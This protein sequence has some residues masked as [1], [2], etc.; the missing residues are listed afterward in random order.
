[1]IGDAKRFKQALKRI[2]RA[3]RGTSE[4]KLRAMARAA[5]GWRD[6]AHQPEPL[7]PAPPP[8]PVVERRRAKMI[9]MVRSGRATVADARRT[10]YYDPPPRHENDD[11]GIW[12]GPGGWD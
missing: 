11:G 8:D 2:A 4:A 6:M 7:P 5:L 1:M 9:D 10:G 3:P 12:N